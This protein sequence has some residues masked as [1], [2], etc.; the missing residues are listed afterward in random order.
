MNSY[1]NHNAHIIVVG[2]E[3][4]GAGKTTS[5]MHIITSL[6]HLGFKVASI[7][8]DSRQ[9]SLTRYLEN[10]E[11][12]RNIKSL[13]LKMSE[14]YIIPLGYGDNIKEVEAQEEAS[15]ITCF[16]DATNNNDFVVI[17]TPGNNS[18]LSRTAH[19]YANT[20]ITPINDSFIDLDVLAKINGDNFKIEKPAIYSQMIWEQKINRISRDKGEINW[21][22]MRNRLSNIDAKN[23]RNVASVLNNL[24]NRIGFKVA[25]GFSERVIFRELFLSGLTLLDLNSL[26]HKS[27]KISHIAAKQ[28]L[29][30]FIKFLDISKIKDIMQKKVM[31]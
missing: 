13:N 10:R 30:E 14:H 8:V 7:D 18:F 27:L 6:L 12:T 5:A 22:V 11:N 31:I 25:P 17:D 28:E 9:K 15:F 20:I 1:N 29:K 21:I 3:K 16:N 23:K 26:G 24:A 2:N 19:S 4:G